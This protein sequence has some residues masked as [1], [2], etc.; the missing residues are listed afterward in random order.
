MAEFQ[1]R[2]D[3]FT[4][5]RIVEGINEPPVGDGELRLAVERFGFSANNITYAAVGHRIGYWQ[6]FPASGNDVDNW[7]VIPVWGFGVVTESNSQEVQ[8]GERVFGY[9][10]PANSLVVR[11]THVA[12]ATFVDGSEHRASLPAGYNTYRRVEG[13]ANYNPDLDDQRMLLWPLLITSFCLWDSLQ[14]KSWYDAQQIIIVSASSKTAIGLAYANHADPAAPNS[15]GLTS[16][17]NLDFVSNLPPYDSAVSYDDLSS[18]DSSIPAVIVDMAGNAEV[19][20]RLYSHLGDNM[21]YCINVGLTH[22]EETE[23]TDVNLRE[24]SEF[25]FAPDHIG[26]R[27]KDWGAAG[28]AQRTSSYIADTTQ[29]CAEWL[30]ITPLAGL[31]GLSDVYQ[32]VC[33]GKVAPDDGLIVVL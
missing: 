15:V 14:Q 6:F 5:S 7:G 27:I 18:I 3:A 10:P 29:S 22:W 2:K 25:F 21:K 24:R 17:R 20:G 26:G 11:P 9:F 4:E 13:E 16:Q 31:Q 28:F 19:L 1:V 33:D 32:E 8:V 30:Q 23:A 12:A